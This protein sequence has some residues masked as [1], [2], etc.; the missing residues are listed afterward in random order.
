MDYRRELFSRFFG[1]P[2]CRQLNAKLVTSLPKIR[3]SFDD[4]AQ[5]GDRFV[6]LIP[7]GSDVGPVEIIRRAFRLQIGRRLITGHN[8]I[9]FSLILLE[10]SQ[11]DV[12]FHIIWIGPDGAFEPVNGLGGLLLIPQY[13]SPGILRIRPVAADG[14]RP[15]KI[16]FGLRFQTNPILTET[17]FGHAQFMRWQPKFFRGKISSV[18]PLRFGGLTSPKI[19]VRPLK[20]KT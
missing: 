20:Q 3:F 15:Q 7:G 18:I 11:I 5:A 13:F 10:K 9:I 14:E 16:V 17:I 4:R 6:P 8:G 19:T 2:L 1:L 12:G